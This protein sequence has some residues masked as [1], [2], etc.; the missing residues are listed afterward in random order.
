[1]KYCDLVMK[2]GIT[3]GIVYPNA[4]LALAKSFRFKSVGGTSAGAIAAAVTAAAALGDR[5]RQAGASMAHADAQVGFEGLAQVSARLATQGFIFSLFQPARGARNAYRALVVMAGKASTLRKFATLLVAV[6]AIAPLEFLLV[7]GMLLALGFAFAGGA[8][9]LAT[10]LPSLACAYGAATLSALLRVARVARGN[11]LGLCSGLRNG[12]SATPALT[13]W[14]HET[15]QRLAGKPMDAP[16]TF[17]D[18]RDAPR[19]PDEPAT[20]GAIAL[21]MITTGVSHR[22]PRTLPFRDVQFWFL[23]EEFDRLFPPSIVDWMVVNGGKAPETVEGKTYYPLPATTRCPCSV[24]TRMSLSFPLLVSAVPLHEPARRLPASESSVQDAAPSREK[25]VAETADHLATGGTPSTSPPAR[26]AAFRTC[27]FSD[28]GISSNFPIHLFDAAMPLWPTF[29]I[30][31]VYPGSDDRAAGERE[32]RDS[33]SM[34]EHNAQGW[35]RTYQPIGERMAVS[36]LV[37]FL[38]GII[39]TMQNWRDLLLARAPGQRDRIVHVA[40]SPQEGGMH[41]D[42]PREVLESIAAK[43]TAAGERL[44]AFRF[45]NHY[46]IRWRCLASA[47]QQYTQS[48]ARTADPRLRVA[49]YAPVYMLPESAETEPPSYAF[50]SYFQRVEST[51]LLQSLIAQGEI[52]N[53]MHPDLAQGAPRPAPQMKVTP[54]Y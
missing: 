1:M 42:M 15:L 51:R 36:E 39:A 19:Y 7:A 27:W 48:V 13:E 26:I 18:L 35:Q 52:W 37:N 33:V 47:L 20:P 5:T 49:D 50:A 6:L 40:L 41:L 16:L 34:P 17:A 43:G 21:R 12:N 28:G 25:N 9:V 10:L 4:V 14:L 2:G 24:A 54:I 8:G 38:F 44:R 11:L 30:D 53:D 31:L 29:A 3:S 46:W 32:D 23:R 45:D 22:E